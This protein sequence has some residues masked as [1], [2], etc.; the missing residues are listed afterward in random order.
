[1]T[2]ESNMH[3]NLA[4]AIDRL[5]EGPPPAAAGSAS[6]AGLARLTHP[7]QPREWELAADDPSAEG[8]ESSAAAAA[9]AAACAPLSISRALSSAESAR[10][11]PQ[12]GAAAEQCFAAVTATMVR[13]TPPDDSTRT[14]GTVNR[15][16][17]D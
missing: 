16:A 11:L 17:V 4:R 10:L 3:H 12:L 2:D 1:M 7:Y 6:D 9:A 15:R 14:R 13:A 8:D 5:P